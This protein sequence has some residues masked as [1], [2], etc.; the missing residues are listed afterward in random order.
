MKNFINYI[1]LG[2]G[3]ASGWAAFNLLLNFVMYLMN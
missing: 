1:G 3:I 2:V